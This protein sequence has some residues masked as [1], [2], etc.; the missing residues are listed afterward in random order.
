MTSHWGSDG[1]VSAAAVGWIDRVSTGDGR[2]VLACA[3]AALRQRHPETVR[4]A[5]SHH[6]DRLDLEYQCQRRSAALHARRPNALPGARRAR[7]HRDQHRRGTRIGIPSLAPTTTSRLGAGRLKLIGFYTQRWGPNFNE[8]TTQPDGATV[9]T[10]SRFSRDSTEGERVL[11]SEYRWR[12]W[13]ADWTLSAEAAYNFIDATSVFEVLDDNGDYFQV[14]PH[15]RC[16]FTRRG[17]ARREHPGFQP[18]LGQAAGRCRS[19]GEWSTA[20]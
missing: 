11:R 18:C 2:L 1:T 8:L 3:G 14:I 19:T 17:E 5:Q 4:Y 6:G 13:D 16:Q 7:D 12:G 10:G 9:P 20:C 15:P